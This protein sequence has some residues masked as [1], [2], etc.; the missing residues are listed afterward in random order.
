MLFLD[1]DGFKSINDTLG[2]LAGDAL[3][4]L[5]AQRVATCLRKTDTGARLGGD[6]FAILLTNLA[7]EPTRRAS[8]RSCSRRCA[9]RCR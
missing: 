3:L 8:P 9:N 4:R 2:H 5:A 6:E 1:L 7:D